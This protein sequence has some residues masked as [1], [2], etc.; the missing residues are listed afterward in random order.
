MTTERRGAETAHAHDPRWVARASR[1]MAL[2]AAWHRLE[3]RGMERVPAGPALLVGN[4]NG[5]ANP[6]DG[7]FLIEWYRQRGMTD[8]VYVLAHEFFFERM[9][10]TPLLARLG[11]IRADPGEAAR[12]LRSGAK[13]LVFPGGDADSLRPW[14]ARRELRFAGRQGY[15]RLAMETGAPIVPVVTAGAHESFVVLGQGRRLARRLGVTRW[16]R[17]HSF[18]VT[19]ALPWGLC[20][21]PA[22]Y[23]PY[24]PFPAKV[25]VEFS[26]PIDP[27]EH[28]DAASLSGAVE[29]V[30]GERLRALYAERG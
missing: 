1:V 12:V 10:L 6:V 21:G 3:L 30:M 17:F 27:A 19:L 26:A 23:L 4:H 15:A 14:S 22:A 11:I 29:S 28:P 18:P 9:R 7:L 24:L 20:V 16:L 8:P 2:Q 13:V 5:G 25:T